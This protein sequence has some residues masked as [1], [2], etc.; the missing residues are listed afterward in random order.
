VPR[1]NILDF[2][3]LI[4]DN[5][6]K[7]LWEKLNNYLKFLEYMIDINRILEQVFNY[8]E[9]E[10]I[11]ILFDIPTKEDNEEWRWRRDLAKEWANKLKADLVSYNATYANNADIP[12]ID[13]SKTDIVIALTEFSATAPLHNYAEEYKI[14]AASMPGFNK[15]MIPALELDFN[16]IRKKVD[17][18]YKKLLVDKIKV[19]FEVDNKKYYLNIDLKNRKP[20]KDDGDCTKPGVINL[21]SGEAFIAPNDTQES[22]TEGILPIQIGDTLNFYKVEHNKII[23]AE[24]ED[25]LIKKVREDPAVGN[26][27]EFAIGVLAEFGIKHC[28]KTLLDEKLGIHIALGRNDHFGGLVSPDKFK[29]KENVWHQDYVYIKEMQPKIKIKIS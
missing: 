20:I 10:K 7:N 3:L 12:E 29:K 24:F 13:L 19:E 2:I 22:E 5:K 16:E 17:D 15:K 9:G 27:A 6:Y 11:T 8:K 23:S 18:A 14:R 26:I 28:G 25:D 1:N 4:N 21:P